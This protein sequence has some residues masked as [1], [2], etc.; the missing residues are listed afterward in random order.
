M[1]TTIS[2]TNRDLLFV[3]DITV[4]STDDDQYRLSSSR[5]DALGLVRVNNPRKAFGPVSTMCASVATGM[6]LCTRLSGREESNL[7]TVKILLMGLTGEVL[8]ERVRVQNLFA[9]DRGYLV[10]S[11]LH[12][13]SECGAKV[14]GTTQRR[15]YFP[16][17]FGKD[18][19]E[20]QRNDRTV[21]QES[22]A[23]GVYWAQRKSRSSGA[24]MLALAFRM[25]CGRVVTL[26][27]TIPDVQIGSFV[28]VEKRLVLPSYST[29]M[30]DYIS[31]HVTPLTS[32][33]GGLDWHIVRAASKTI[34]STISFTLIS[35]FQ[36]ELDPDDHRI[37]QIIGITMRNKYIDL[38]TFEELN[39]LS[40]SELKV[41]LRD[42][43]IQVSGSKRALIEKLQ[44]APPLE[45][46]IRQELMD[47]WFRK[48][49]RKTADMKAGNANEVNISAALPRFI[50]T[51]SH[52]S[53]KILELVEL[54]LVS[55]AGSEHLST[56]VDRLARMKINSQECFFAVE[57]KTMTRMRTSNAAAERLSLLG[58]GSSRLVDTEF[59]SDT[60][61]SLVWTLPYRC[62]LLH[63]AVVLN[64]PAVIFVV[65]NS[66][67]IIYAVICH[68]PA[69][70]IQQYLS[71]MGRIGR[72]LSQMS[73][74]SLDGID[75]KHAVDT[76]TVLLW[77]KLG[78]S[79]TST[80][81]RQHVSPG[82]TDLKPAHAIVPT[83]VSLWNNVKG[84]IPEMENYDYSAVLL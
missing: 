80:N 25:G 59:G 43:K 6:A 23:L 57:F 71:M 49:L 51:E 29:E 77:S 56:S 13:L 50:E 2:Q 83:L 33:Q 79:I 28:Y 32:S 84:S 19:I 63:H 21:I 54:G 12:W 7:Q 60:F 22:G 75:F 35:I 40:I 44:S 47:V 14:I 20:N 42:R 52:G 38:G 10:P 53:M 4:L 3:K 41:L 31:K 58:V 24:R 81:L 78:E 46:N 27:T 1:E 17:T 48:P 18:L 11:V 65:A 34:T 69:Q 30:A 66:S 37:L 15:R 39:K 16:F 64:T 62:Q 36:N 67:T 70:I 5:V 76:D 55:R 26:L 8:P 9:M 72:R 74:S 68:C 73:F 61:K 45:K 82:R